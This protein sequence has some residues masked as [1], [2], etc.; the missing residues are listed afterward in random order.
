VLAAR[1]DCVSGPAFV[2]SIQMLD[3]ILLAVGVG[4]FVML[5]GYAYACERL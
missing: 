3:I 2:R 5:I 1:V 4:F